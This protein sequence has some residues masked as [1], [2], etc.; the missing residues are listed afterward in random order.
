[1]V[2]PS[3][4]LAPVS[5][6]SPSGYLRGGMAGLLNYD[7]FSSLSK[8]P[9][10]TS[11]HSYVS[12]ENGFN[13]G[14]WQ[15]RS[16]QIINQSKSGTQFT[17]LQTYAQ[18]TFTN[19]GLQLQAGQI[20]VRS[21]LFAIPSLSGMQIEPDR[22]LNPVSGSGITVTGIAQTPQARVE[23]KQNNQLIYSTLVPA[24]RFTLPDVPTISANTD[25]QVTVNETNGE[26]HHFVVS[27]SEQNAAQLSQ[28][29]GL[30]FALGKVRQESGGQV[31]PW[32]GSFSQGWRINSQ[33]NLSG[34]ALLAQG[35]QSLA[36]R[37]EFMPLKNWL[38]RSSWW[39]SHDQQH[40]VQGQNLELSSTYR[41]LKNVGI[42][43]R[44]GH[45]SAGYRH[46]TDS[47]YQNHQQGL[48]THTFGASAHWSLSYLGGF[49]LGYTRFVSQQTTQSINI[50]WGKTIGKVN[51]RADWQQGLGRSS[52]KNNADQLFVNV[53]LPWGEQHIDNY[54]R[55]SGRRSTM[56][57]SINTHGKITPALNY[58]LAAN[59][60]FTEKHTGIRGSLNSNLHYTKVNVSASIDTNRRQNY[61]VSTQGGV[62]A[63]A[64]G[65]TFS[66]EP[67]QE[68]FAI[69]KLDQKVAGIAID[70]G[71]GRVWTD[72]WGQAVV[73]SLPAYQSSNV[74]LNT[75]TLP[76]NA[77]VR[78][79]LQSVKVGRGA[80]T[81]LNYQLLRERRA[82]L[83][84]TL[85]D[86]RPLPKDSL[87]VDSN[88]QYI[89]SSVDNGVV[90]I[91]NIPASGTLLVAAENGNEACRLM[92]PLNE[93]PDLENYYET[94]AATCVF[95]KA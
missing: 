45:S 7:M 2:V 54:Y 59:H 91:N 21:S 38:L 74:E 15:V 83:N 18:R 86:G 60:E 67:I 13:A 31:L 35:Y 5:T 14:D 27:A 16:R 93:Q 92:Y 25:L 47:M 6:A 56:G 80:V 8:S 26:K 53:S 40:S 90:F 82:L 4:A 76:K 87:I 62:V 89:T 70:T 52:T 33:L 49:S 41:P 42:T 68:S 32:V 57:S 58:S 65:I 28:P 55:R 79:G 71:Q 1:M 81:Q 72:F 20:N 10:D 39:L 75:E 22:A 95:E 11:R 84:V 78:N 63:H 30:S 64:A 36:A 88:Q 23:I 73:P 9:W 3:D 94:L 66:P 48:S 37:G 46:L 51:I 44:A 50:G 69:V 17:A 43:V 19:V 34:G 24:G 85:P 77:D 29:E 12:L 61:N